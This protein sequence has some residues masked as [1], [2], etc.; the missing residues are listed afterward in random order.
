MGDQKTILPKIVSR[1]EWFEARNVLKAEEEEFAKER[2]ALVAKRRKL[3]MV[4]MGDE[5]FFESPDGKVGLIDLFD[6]RRQLMV[7]HFWFEPGGDPCEGCSA[8]TRDL[9]DLGGNFAS[10]RKYDTALAYVSRAPADEIAGVRE[11][12]SWTMPW[13]SLVGEDFL[14][15]TGYGGWAQISVFLRDCDTAYLAN[16]APFDD[17]VNIGNHWTLLE[18]TPLGIPED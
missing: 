5:Y 17:L 16:I 7:Y 14:D 13:Y 11:R 9:G 15:A 1:D 8:W 4:E 12:R 3:P 2:G 10:L 6:G 18:R